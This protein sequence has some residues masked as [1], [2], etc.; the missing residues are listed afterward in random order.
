V[1][2]VTTEHFGQRSA[3]RLEAQGIWASRAQKYLTMAGTVAVITA[4]LVASAAGLPAAV[5]SSHSPWAAFPAG[6]ATGT[7]A[8][9]RRSSTGY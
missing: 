8:W 9:T 5:L 3:E 2:F 6:A 4:T 7:A 1:T